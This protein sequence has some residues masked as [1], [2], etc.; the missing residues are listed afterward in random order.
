MFYSVVLVSAI[1]QRESAIGCIYVAAAAAL[2]Y[3]EERYCCSEDKFTITVCG[4]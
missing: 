2:K 3:T 4:R 1:R